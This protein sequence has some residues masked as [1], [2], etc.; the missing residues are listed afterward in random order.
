[1]S[2]RASVFTP[3]VASGLRP[4][5]EPIVLAE[6]LVV[7]PWVVRRARAPGPGGSLVSRR[8]NLIEPTIILTRR[9]RWP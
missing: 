5:E 8:G 2:E 1:M 7:G 6:G 4:P 9:R 3:V